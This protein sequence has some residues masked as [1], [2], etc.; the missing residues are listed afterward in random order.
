MGETP[1]L[2]IFDAGTDPGPSFLDLLRR[3]APEALAMPAA[4]SGAP[5]CGF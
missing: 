5:F 2:P 1:L 3:V 4:P